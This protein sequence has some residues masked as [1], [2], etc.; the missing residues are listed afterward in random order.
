M[1]YLVEIVTSAILGVLIAVFMSFSGSTRI[2]N[3]PL[4]QDQVPAATATTT[5]VAIVPT[6]AATA[7]TAPPVPKKITPPKPVPP[8]PT[9]TPVSTA[10]NASVQVPVTPPPSA[11]AVVEAVREA[12]V[13]IIC[14]TKTGGSFNSISGSGVMIDGRGVILTNAHVG[15][16][17]LLGDYPEPGFVNCVIR[18]GNPA[19]PRYTAD[20]LFLPPSWIATNA[21]KITESDPTGNGEHDYALLRVTGAVSS[22]TQIPLSLPHLAISVAPP[23]ENQDVFL[24]G[25]AAGFL[26]GI[27]ISNNLYESS[28]QS[29][30]GDLFTFASSTLDLF[31]V[32]GTV[33]AQKGSS[34]GAVTDTDGILIGL[35]VTAT[36]AADT[37]SRDLRA[38]STP[39]I[40]R[41]FERESGM[42]LQAFLS[43]DLASRQA[44]FSSSIE[45]A[46]RASLKSALGSH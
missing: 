34:G 42:P 15:Q 32:G 17:L 37:G 38:I 13:N 6:P 14:T 3:A 18:T 1:P 24:A 31:S 35:I 26:G 23:G 7:T 28:S 44:W 29:T 22:S 9:E 20:L 30:V 41:D 39:Y 25:Y 43:G 33:V 21:A 5:P 4:P 16:Y 2:A 19:Y 46:L 36:E 40:I 11:A 8:A 45:P 10:E 12:V 27:A